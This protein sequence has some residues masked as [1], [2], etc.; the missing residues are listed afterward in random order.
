MAERETLGRIV[1]A[2]WV[3]WA[4][5]QPDPKPSWLVG[6]DDLDEGQREVD[7]RI[8]EAVAAVE[9]DRCIKIAQEAAT[10]LRDS[11]TAH[12]PWL[13]GAD[14]LE[15]LASVLQEAP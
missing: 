13:I 1:R 15:I 5:E 8:G 4:L 12:A 7:C 9:R 14:A 3:T 11:T 6:W 10:G 2:I